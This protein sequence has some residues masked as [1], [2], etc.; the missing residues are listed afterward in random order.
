MATYFHPSRSRN[1]AAAS[2]RL[3]RFF[4]PPS[5]LPASRFLVTLKRLAQ[6][7]LQCFGALSRVE[8][9]TLFPQ[10]H[11]RTTSADFRGALPMIAAHDLEQ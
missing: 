11:T 1:A 3:A 2:M 10:G 8:L 6:L 9:L 7:A 4:N 5:L